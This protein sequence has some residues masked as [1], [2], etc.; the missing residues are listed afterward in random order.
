MQKKAI[1]QSPKWMKSPVKPVGAA[2]W[3]PGPAEASRQTMI[4]I[5]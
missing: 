4:L 2:L 3:L 1:F 5:V